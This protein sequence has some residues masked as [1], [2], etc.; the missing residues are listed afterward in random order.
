MVSQNTKDNIERQSSN[1]DVKRLY[2]EK[3]IANLRNEGYSARAIE[4]IVF[5]ADKYRA[6]PS[7][8]ANSLGQGYN[9][10]QISEIYENARNKKFD[11]NIVKSFYDMFKP[12]KGKLSEMI[13][14]ISNESLIY[15]IYSR[16]GDNGPLCSV[17]KA[18]EGLTNLGKDYEGNFEK[19]LQG[20]I[21]R[22]EL[23]DEESWE[24]DNEAFAKGINCYC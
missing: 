13:K 23:A 17:S 15:E 19:T 7:K 12:G 5:V 24:L 18:L 3:S 8:I 16:V 9:I 11:V 4:D 21:N 6:R 10:N 14:K 22:K 2:G 1:P 20:L